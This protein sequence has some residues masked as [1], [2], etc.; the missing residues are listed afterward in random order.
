[1]KING[2][3]KNEPGREVRSEDV[4]AI[5]FTHCSDDHEK[6]WEVEVGEGFDYACDVIERAGVRDQSLH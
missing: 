6:E 1:L 2:E 3:W 4:H 5:V